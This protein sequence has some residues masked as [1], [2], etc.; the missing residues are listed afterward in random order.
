VVYTGEKTEKKKPSVS[1]RALCFIVLSFL[2]YNLHIITSVLLNGLLFKALLLRL[3]LLIAGM[4]YNIFET[5]IQ[6]ISG[7]PKY[8][9]VFFRVSALF[10]S[11]GKRQT[12]ADIIILMALLPT[13]INLLGVGIKI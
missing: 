7:L 8:C 12:D 9:Q 11:K 3:L 2:A 10:Y 6:S 4:L 1:R 13:L 5:K